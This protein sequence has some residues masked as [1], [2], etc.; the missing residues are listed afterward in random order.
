MKKFFVDSSAFIALFN[1]RE[2]DH[3]EAVSLFNQ[4][5][6]G[7]TLYTSDYVLDEVVTFCQARYGHKQACSAATA[8]LK[9]DFIQLIPLDR[10]GVEKTY[11]RF[12][13]TSV[14][15]VSFTDVSSVVLM[16]AFQ[17][18]AVFT[19]DSHFK[20]MG[21]RLCYEKNSL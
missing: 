4:L 2:Q 19:F 14:P 8:I 18:D 5:L 16:D 12:L 13:K 6:A 15:G 10:K 20:K 21:C 7:G 9:S 11:E 1:K 3:L 17:M